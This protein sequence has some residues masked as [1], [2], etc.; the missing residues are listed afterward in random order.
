MK[1]LITGWSGFVGKNLLP[2]LKNHELL[3]FKRNLEEV[4]QF[5]PDVIYSLAEEIYD[6]NKMFEANVK[7]IND[8]LFT[9]NNYKAFIHVGSSSE[10]GRKQNPIKETD[11]LNPTTWY[12]GTKAA[13]SLLCQSFAKQFNEPIIVV[14]PFS[15]YGPKDNEKKLIPTLIRK[16]KTDKKI[17]LSHAMHDYVYIEDFIDGIMSFSNGNFDY[18]DIVN[19][20]SGIQYDNEEIARFIE[21]IMNIKFDIEFVE[22]IK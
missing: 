12:E 16:A 20:G 14:R 7:L 6:T 21:K 9:L 13:G 18:G 5:K 2:K 17:T 11:Y 8:L 15:L 19:F 3:L 10:F 4:K 22:R 1:I